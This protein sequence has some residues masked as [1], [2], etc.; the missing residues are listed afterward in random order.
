MGAPSSDLIAEFFLQHT[1]NTHVATLSHKHKIIN[2]IRYVDDVL[3]I[4]DSTH[5]PTFTISSQV[6]TP[7]TLT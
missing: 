2:Y 4:Y 5:T 3:V 7:Y 6:L 1:E